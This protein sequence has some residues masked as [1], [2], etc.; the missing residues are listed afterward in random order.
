VSSLGWVMMDF[1]PIVVISSLSGSSA[2]VA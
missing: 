1:A 2:D